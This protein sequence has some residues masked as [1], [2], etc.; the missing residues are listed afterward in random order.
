[1]RRPSSRRS[2]TTSPT[3]TP[4]HAR[5]ARPDHFPGAAGATGSAV[6]TGSPVDLGRD[7]L[8]HYLRIFG[9]HAEGLHVDVDLV[10]GSANLCAAVQFT[11]EDADERARHV[12]VLARWHQLQEPVTRVL[13]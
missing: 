3:A 6:S 4:S 2:R 5:M 12:A 11:F 10:G 9:V 7:D 13:V 1:M 8:V